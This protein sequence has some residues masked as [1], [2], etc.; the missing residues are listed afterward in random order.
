MREAGCAGSAVQ[1]DV[2]I[3]DVTL[4]DGSGVDVAVRLKELAPQLKILFVSGYALDELSDPDSAL[5]R[6]LPRDS[7]RFLRKPYCARE[8][9]AG[10]LELAGYGNLSLPAA[11]T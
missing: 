9:I 5:Y 3:A 2:L 4:A 1:I 6:L 7:V 8:L 10:I 11:P